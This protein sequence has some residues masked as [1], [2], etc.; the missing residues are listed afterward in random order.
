[1]RNGIHF[2][3]AGAINEAAVATEK[4]ISICLQLSCGH[5]KYEPQDITFFRAFWPLQIS[6]LTF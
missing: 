2:S 4:V 1:M 5:T 6:S 3:L